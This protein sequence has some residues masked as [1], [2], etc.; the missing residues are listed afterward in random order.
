MKRPLSYAD[1]F[2]TGLG[3]F[4]LI[5]IALL[6]NATPGFAVAYRDMG[7]MH[8]PA[9]TK[10]VLSTG[11]RVIVPALLISAIVA[12]HVWRPRYLL[13]ALAVTTLATAGF[14]YWAAY[15]PIFAIAGNIR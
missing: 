4:G 5:A 8:L 14:W 10:L 15:Q 2:G 6:A 1:G 11:W 3:V 12:A 9:V 7:D 13:V